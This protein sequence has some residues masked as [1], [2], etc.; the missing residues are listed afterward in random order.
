M[1][2]KFINAYILLVTGCLFLSSLLLLPE[3]NVIAQQPTVAIPT[4]TGTPQGPVVS[5][6]AQEQDQINI[7][8]GPGT[9]Y[10]KVGVLIINQTVPAK[11]RSVGGDWIMVEYPGVDGGVAWVYA[12]L[13]TLSGG[14]LP[15]VEPPSTPTPLYTPTIDPTLAARFV[16][17]AQPT[18]MPTFTPPSPLVIPEFEENS[19][20]ELPGNVPMGLVILV[21]GAGGIFIGLFTLAQGGR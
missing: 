19:S 7:R 11:G 20:L 3:T 16:V 12:P 2:N 15:I 21:L 13:V 18:R 17:T 10:P 5:V 6:R 14:E 8:S 9:T 4:V 1:K